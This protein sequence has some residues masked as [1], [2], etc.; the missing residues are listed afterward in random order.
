MLSAVSVTDTCSYQRKYYRFL[1]MSSFPYYLKEMNMF[2]SYRP[3]YA[4]DYSKADKRGTREGQDA[5][6]R[7]LC[8]VVNGEHASDGRLTICSQTIASVSCSNTHTLV[9]QHFECTLQLNELLKNSGN[10]HCA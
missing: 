8:R 4:C 6:E 10:C 1:S 9:Q 3:V 2:A 5:D 7:T